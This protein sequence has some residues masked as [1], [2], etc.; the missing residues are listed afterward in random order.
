MIF[1]IIMINIVGILLEYAYT[2]IYYY[3]IITIFKVL[4]YSLLFKKEKILKCYFN[5]IKAKRKL[6]LWFSILSIKMFIDLILLNE[7]ECCFCC[8]RYL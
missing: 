6:S 4:F 7:S 5:F 1:I 3:G 2:P 8:L